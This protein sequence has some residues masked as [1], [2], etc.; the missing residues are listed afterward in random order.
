MG[1]ANVSTLGGVAAI[2][3]SLPAGGTGRD[4]S[5]V[6]VHQAAPLA[7]LHSVALIWPSEWEKIQRL[8]VVDHPIRVI[9]RRTPEVDLESP[10]L[11]ITEPGKW[12]GRAGSPQGCCLPQK[13]G[14][15]CPWAIGTYAG[16]MGMSE[17]PE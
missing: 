17:V 5:L 4:A 12:V 7:S 1:T 2:D 8:F 6:L 14:I 15:N 9:R 11:Y 10:P 13:L 3:L 16:F